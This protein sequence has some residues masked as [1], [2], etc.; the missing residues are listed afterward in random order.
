MAPRTARYV[1]VGAG[2]HGLSTAWHL[3]R[4]LRARGEAPDVVVLDKAGVAAGASGIAC[5]VVRNNYFQPA[6]RGLMAHSVAVWESD[7]AAFHYHPVGYVQ[8]GPEAMRADVRQIFTEQQAIGYPS[9]FI[10]GETESREY[11][12]GLFPDWRAEGIACVLHEHRGGYAENVASVRALAANAEAAGVH[13]VEGVRATGLDPDTRTVTTDDG[14]VTCEQVVVAAAAQRLGRAVRWHE[15]RSESMVSLMHGRAQHQ[16]IDVG[17]TRDG[18]ITGVRMHLISDAGAYATPTAVRVLP[19]MSHLMAC[20]TYRIPKV[21]FRAQIVTTNTTPITAYRGAGRPEV[22]AMLERA[23]DLVAA[24]LGVDPVE[25]RRRNLIPKEAFPYTTPTGAEYDSGDYEGALDEALRLAGYRRLRAEQA[26]RR[27]GGSTVLIGIGLSTYVE[28][29]AARPLDRELAAMRIEHDGSVTVRVGVSP[30]GQG[31]ET[32]MAQLVAGRLRVPMSS[33]RVIHSDTA[34]VPGGTGT[35]S[36]RSLQI[37]G[38]AALQATET[39]VAKARRLAATL[40]E[41]AEADLAISPDGGLVVRGSPGTGLSWAELA[42]IA[43]DPT[44]LPEGMEPGLHAE[45][46]FDQ[47]AATFPAGAHVSV[48]EVDTETG[49]VRVLRHI[50]VDDAGRLLNPLLANGQIHGGL[51]Q[52]ISQALYEQVVY[53]DAGNPLT[54]TLAD[55]LV[56]AAPD[57]PAFEARQRET[58]SPHNPMGMKGIGEA[59]T[60]GSVPAVQNAVVDALSHL[61][62]RHLDMPLTPERVWRAIQAAGGSG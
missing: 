44:S 26:E 25:V 7:P 22:T 59:S 33:V 43:E 55:Y 50:A 16:Y 58:A 17:A 3:A 24:E 30:Q 53:D 19:A 37:G 56:P 18:L 60:I 2:V 38:S 57:L 49:M 45:E 31:H 20:G 52:G 36:S 1:V 11:L 21:D 6:M 5:G 51:A 41:A 27:A 12:R 28:V 14:E 4:G 8:A 39:V 47:Q 48:V 61:G 23:V 54:S 29:T 32:A 42:T 35:M 15:T 40:L 34:A 9:T 62:V 46:T 10:E 13:I